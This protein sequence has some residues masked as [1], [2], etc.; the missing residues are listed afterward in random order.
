MRIIVTL[1]ALIIL[2]GCAEDYKQKTKDIPVAPPRDRQELLQD[3]FIQAE[4]AYEKKIEEGKILQGKKNLALLKAEKDEFKGTTFYTDKSNT[5]FRNSVYI[6]IGHS[7]GEPFLRFK[8]EFTADSWLFVRNI[9]FLVDGRKFEFF[10]EK[11]ERDNDTDIYEWTDD[12][13]D[14]NTHEIIAA[15]LNGKQVKMRYNGDQYY[16]DRVV[17]QKEITAMRRVASAYFA[18][19]GRKWKFD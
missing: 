16:H 15:I 6:Y 10:P 14:E 13:V 2:S 18:L 17:S 1:A 8:T 4:K 12:L 9:T 3:S 7:Y 5:R 11:V 19:G